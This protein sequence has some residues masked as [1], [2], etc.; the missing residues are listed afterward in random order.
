M[1]YI[2]SIEKAIEKEVKKVKR[3]L[4]QLYIKTSIFF[5]FVSLQQQVIFQINKSIIK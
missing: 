5:C 2:T 4:M 1:E 3:Y